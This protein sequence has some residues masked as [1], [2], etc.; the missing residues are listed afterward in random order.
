MGRRLTEDERREM[1]EYARELEA[2]P[3]EERER[4]RREINLAMRRL[5]FRKHNVAPGQGIAPGFI[6]G[7]AATGDT[8]PVDE[9]KALLD[10]NARGGAR[11]LRAEWFRRHALAVGGAVFH[12]PPGFELPADPPTPEDG[13]DE[14]TI[15]GPQP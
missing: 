14:P 8:D 4:R 7:A 12:L 15:V 6:P 1:G 3:P 5:W 13:P 10:E 2:L 11:A 9:T